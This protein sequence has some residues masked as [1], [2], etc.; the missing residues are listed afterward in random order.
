MWDVHNFR[1]RLRHFDEMTQEPLQNILLPKSSVSEI[2]LPFL[3][4]EARG[5]SVLPGVD[6][7]GVS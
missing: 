6:T 2:I 7:K 1:F 3:R 4:Y 5:Y